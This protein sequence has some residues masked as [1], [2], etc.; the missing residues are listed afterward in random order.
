V[1]SERYA[2]IPLI[3]SLISSPPEATTDFP[4]TLGPRRPAQK[5]E[6]TLCT[7]VHQQGE[8]RKDEGG[9]E[10]RAGEATIRRGVSCH[11][12]FRSTDGVY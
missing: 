7:K 1:H 3:A 8:M 5:D 11:F 6:N 10:H 12:T 4:G 2:P 9:C